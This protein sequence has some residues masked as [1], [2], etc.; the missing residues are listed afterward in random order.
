MSIEISEEQR[1]LIILALARLS[2][3][4]PGWFFMCERTALQMDKRKP[5][6]SA[7]MFE[8]LRQIYAAPLTAAL[9]GEPIEKILCPTSSA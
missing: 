8:E 7:Q 9:S 4:R 5:D 6:G 2:M 3:E 1:Q